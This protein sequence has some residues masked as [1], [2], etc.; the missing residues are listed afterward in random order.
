MVSLDL[1]AL[2]VTLILSVLLFLLQR[3]F[4]SPF[5]KISQER[6]KILRENDDEFTNYLSQFH[7][8]EKILNDLLK[9]A[10]EKAEEHKEN[11]KKEAMTEKEK[12]IAMAKSDAEKMKREAM[13]KLDDE[14][15]HGRRKIEE[16][17]NSLSDD[18]IE[19]ILEG[20]N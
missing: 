1:T 15:E 10:R 17:V 6:Q 8:K 7:E 18:L 5:S 2:F 19:N 4:F 3:F 14:L 13:K 20:R 9:E 11:I 12:V 16:E